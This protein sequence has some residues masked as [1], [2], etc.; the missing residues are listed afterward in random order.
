MANKD[1]MAEGS[2]SKGASK[3]DGGFNFWACQ[4]EKYAF[5]PDLKFPDL[6]LP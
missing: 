3:D 1:F 2:E 4:L 6:Q 5:F